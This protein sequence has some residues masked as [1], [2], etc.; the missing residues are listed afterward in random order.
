MEFAACTH[1][2]KIRKANEDNY[3]IPTPDG[4]NYCQCFFAVADGMGGHNAGEIASAL[5]IRGMLNFLGKPGKLQD[6]M[7]RPKST[8]MD[9]V[10][11]TN[12]KIWMLGS[13]SEKCANMGTTLTCALCLP[14][15]WVVAHVGDTRAYHIRGEQILQVTRDHSMVEDLVEQGVMEKDSPEYIMQRHILTRALGVQRDEPGEVYQVPAQAG[16]LL[17][18]CSDGLSENVSPQEM[19]EICSRMELQ[20]ACEAMRDLALNR[21]GTDNITLC[22]CRWSEEVA[23]HG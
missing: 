7:E 21:G 16:D 12:K 19:L 8:L 23:L 13:F 1:V 2:G 14:G 4:E 9:G 3:Y 22:I 6:A 10:D 18:I 17:L 11:S 5:A 15:R 20:S